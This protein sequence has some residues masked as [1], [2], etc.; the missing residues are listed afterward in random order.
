MR[1]ARP[2]TAH[3]PFL[4]P[5]R[6]IAL[7]VGVEAT[8]AYIGSARDAAGSALA[9]ARILNAALPPLGQDGG[10]IAEF[11]QRQQALY[12]LLHGQLLHCPLQVREQRSVVLVVGQVACAPLARDALPAAISRQPRV[13]QLLDEALPIALGRP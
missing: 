3:R 12:L 2:G 13:Q 9:G 11:A 6:V 8:Y 4:L 7:P 10:F 5:G 1:V